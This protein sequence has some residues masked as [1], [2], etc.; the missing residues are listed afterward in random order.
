MTPPSDALVFDTG[1]LRHFAVNGWL[2]VLKFL[3]GDRPVIVPESVEHELKYQVHDHPA[4][5]Q[6]LDAGW[7]SVDRSNDV[8][9]LMAFAAYEQRLVAN[10]RNRGECG[11]LALGKTRGFETVLD[12]SVPRTIAE[13]EGIRVTATLPLLCS[14]IR[15]GQLTV[16]M[17]E[18]LADDLIAGEYFLPF[19]PGGFRRWAQEQGLIEY[20]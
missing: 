15:E 8:T 14:A 16:P 6:V 7:I 12:D 18:A 20:Q 5:R 13:E 2:G 9:F 4:L 10:G 3:A 19:G 17:V 11:V 1:P